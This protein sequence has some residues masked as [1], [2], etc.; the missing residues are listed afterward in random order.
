MTDLIAFAKPRPAEPITDAEPEPSIRDPESDP[1]DRRTDRRRRSIEGL[2][3]PHLAGLQTISDRRSV[4]SPV[5]GEGVGMN[6]FRGKAP[7]ARA[8][9]GTPTRA[10]RRHRRTERSSTRRPSGSH[11]LPAQPLASVLTPSN[12]GEPGGLRRRRHRA[13]RG[14][15]EQRREPRLG[16]HER[17]RPRARALRLRARRSHAPRPHRRPRERPARG[18]S[19]RVAPR[20]RRA[21]PEPRAARGTT[22]TPSFSRVS[23]RFLYPE[24]RVS[25]GY[26]SRRG[27]GA[28]PPP[29]PNEPP[30]ATVPSPPRARDRRPRR[31][32]GPR[33]S[34]L[35]RPRAKTPSRAP[36]RSDLSPP[37]PRGNEHASR[38]S[39]GRARRSMFSFTRVVVLARAPPPLFL[40]M[41]FS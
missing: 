12:H 37:R 21:L 20:S 13:R 33:A 34:G 4:R 6:L 5:A 29:H 15:G 26:N 36:R 28:E 39:R 22:T 27:G 2:F 41:P 14:T 19:P 7:A 10:L 23:R 17:R 38:F 1:G 3:R 8:R 31:A 16:L 11:T 9:A 32:T 18:A 25:G 35:P 30:R 24:R 40:P